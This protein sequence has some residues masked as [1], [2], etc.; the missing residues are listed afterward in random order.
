MHFGLLHEEVIREK[1]KA[2]QSSMPFINLL[3]RSLTGLL[4]KE[5]I[6]EKFK[7]AQSS[8]PFINLLHMCFLF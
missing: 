1:F 7:A 6:K 2:A 8:M 4:H 3:D 5:V